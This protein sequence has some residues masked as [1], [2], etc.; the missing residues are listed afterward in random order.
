MW[1]R[2]ASY[3]PMKAAAEGKKKQEA[4]KVSHASKYNAD[5]CEMLLLTYLLFNIRL[6]ST[7]VD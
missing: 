2:R 1:R 5:R 7:Q 6:I 4:R 3:D